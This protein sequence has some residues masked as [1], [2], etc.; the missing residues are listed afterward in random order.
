MNIPEEKPGVV[1][2]EP[3]IQPPNIEQTISSQLDS[4]NR[5]LNAK[6]REQHPNYRNLFDAQGF[7]VDCNP[8]L[9]AKSLTAIHVTDLNNGE[10]LQ[11]FV[12]S[13]VTCLDD[14]ALVSTLD[15]KECKELGEFKKNLDKDKFSA[16]L[17]SLYQEH[18]S[19]VIN[20]ER[21][22]RFKLTQVAQTINKCLDT[23]EKKAKLDQCYQETLDNYLPR[24]KLKFVFALIHAYQPDGSISISKLNSELDKSRVDLKNNM[25]L[26]FNSKLGNAEIKPNKTK[27][28]L[29]ELL[30][31]TPAF[32]DMHIVE[33]RGGKVNY[34][35]TSQ[36]TS[37]DEETD[38]DAVIPVSQYRLNGEGGLKSEFNQLRLPLFIP[39]QSVAKAKCAPENQNAEQIKAKQIEIAVERMLRIIR[40]RF[41]G[42]EP[43]FQ[44]LLTSYHFIEWAES[45][46]E[47]TSRA[48][49]LPEIQDKINQALL[50]ENPE[51]QLYFPLLTPV[52]G[53]GVDIN[54]TM[55]SSSV[56]NL[57][58]RN[59]MAL[60]MQIGTQ[61]QK[62]ELLIKYKAKLRGEP[63]A[64]QELANYISGLQLQFTADD[65]PKVKLLKMIFNYQLSGVREYAKLASTLFC[66]N[67]DNGRLIFGCK[68]GNERT[69]MILY[70]QE[71]IN[72]L[73]RENIE[74]LPDETEAKRVLLDLSNRLDLE[75]N[76]TNINGVSQYISLNDQGA[77]AKIK[78]KEGLAGL[79]NTN[80][81]EASLKNLKNSNTKTSN[82]DKLQA[83]KD[84]SVA[85]MLS[86]EPPKSF[87]LKLAEAICKHYK[88][89][90]LFAAVLLIAG[91]CLFAPQF[92][93]AACF[94]VKVTLL[95][96]GFASAMLGLMGGIKHRNEHSAVLQENSVL[97][98]PSSDESQQSNT[99]APQLK[100]N[101]L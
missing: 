62:D 7:F 4:A 92:V 13:L 41:P 35:H 33:S 70:R 45:G 95:A 18:S 24:A 11:P 89:I 88:K 67:V 51:H 69:A 48:Q 49:L 98:Q 29:Q 68:S 90:L 8:S 1:G 58:L 15:K 52:N 64:D 31:T 80:Y 20:L 14:W 27:K 28:D 43:V 22:M 94:A 79:Y 17:I 84:K 78:A 93:L 42:N 30:E 2:L 57:A 40:E 12:N 39:K 9:D 82:V 76:E 71:C 47:Q 44:N 36:Y 3:A 5:A 77:E 97:K 81:A 37:H 65:T 26:F 55:F 87:M 72:E 56:S 10:H 73:L 46:N 25:L 23:P 91:A 59:Q 75:V 19:A 100:M 66:S 32:T 63:N 61:E 16:A 60:L 99:P 53:F 21:A 74:I 38:H 96:L 50:L 101:R 34:L 83:H 6:L 86:N 54:S 85:K